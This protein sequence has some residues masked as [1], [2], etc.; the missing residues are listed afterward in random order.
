MILYSPIQNT[1][2]MI[3]ANM[4]QFKIPPEYE[5]D[6]RSDTRLFTPDLSTQIMVESM[7]YPLPPLVD[8]SGLLVAYGE[9]EVE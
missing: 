9:K 5:A 8:V 2:Y 1:G 3:H 4:K 7:T 6:Y